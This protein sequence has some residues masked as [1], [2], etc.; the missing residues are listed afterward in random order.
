MCCTTA[1]E[2]QGV[3][4]DLWQDVFVAK[5]TQYDA[6]I[7]LLEEAV[8]NAHQAMS[9]SSLARWQETM[10]DLASHA[11]TDALDSSMPQSKRSRAVVS[12]IPR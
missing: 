1:R 10:P 6:L 4:R 11:I 5:L 2:M 3:C 12:E 8:P 9:T 7:W